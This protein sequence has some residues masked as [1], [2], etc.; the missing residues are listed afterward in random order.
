MIEIKKSL[1]NLCNL[2]IFISLISISSASGDEVV[3]CNS[4]PM[5]DLDW[6]GQVLLP[7]FDS[8]MGILRSV[9]ID[10][11]L[12]MSQIYMIENTGRGKSTINSTTISDMVLS[13]LDGDRIVANAT[14]RLSKDLGPFDGSEDFLGSSGLNLTQEASSDTVRYTTEDIDGYVSDGQDDIVRLKVVMNSSHDMIISGAA[15]SS[16]MTTAGSDVCIVYRYD[17]AEPI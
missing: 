14:V 11:I 5:Q 6:S 4:T 16:V 8:G 2:L 9:E 7:K 10:L 15:L 13:A 12:N 17:K 1:L 3:F